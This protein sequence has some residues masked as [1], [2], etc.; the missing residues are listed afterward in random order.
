MVVIGGI[1]INALV[2]S[3]AYLPPLLGRTLAGAGDTAEIFISAEQEFLEIV[4]D[5]ILN[6]FWSWAIGAEFWREP[7]IDPVGFLLDGEGV[8]AGRKHTFEAEVHIF[9]QDTHRGTVG[10][11]ADGVACWDVAFAFD[12]FCAI[13]VQ[14][15]FNQAVKLTNFLNGNAS[16]TAFCD[17][18]ELLWEALGAVWKVFHI[19][20][21][22]LEEDDVQL[23][24][25]AVHFVIDKVAE[26]SW[27]F[28]HHVPRLLADCEV[29]NLAVCCGELPFKGRRDADYG[30]YDCIGFRGGNDCEFGLWF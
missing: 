12:L 24:A 15:D 30:T 25:E 21:L 11:A 20:L 3:P 28:V 7:R 5:E 4:G 18:V 8:H 13:K 16:L 14:R 27:V 23:V 17:S 10:S 9:D 26:P 1:I 2:S 19:A 22:A 6:R 29:W